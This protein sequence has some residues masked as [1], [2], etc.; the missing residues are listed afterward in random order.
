MTRPGSPRPCTTA[1]APARRA[2]TGISSLAGSGWTSLL[3]LPLLRQPALILAGDDDPIIPLANARLMNRLIPHSQLHV[4]HGG[5]LSLVTEAAE[6]APVV[7][8][9]L[10]APLARRNCAGSPG[11]RW[12]RASTRG[13][14]GWPARCPGARPGR[15]RREVHPPQAG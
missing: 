8:G 11:T 4:S 15:S 7:D 14:S 10:T 2:A 13:R 12:R 1:T 9:F 5:H 6:L 3:F